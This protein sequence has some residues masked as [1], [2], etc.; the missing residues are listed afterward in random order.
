MSVTVRYGQMERM[1]KDCAQGYDIRRTTHGYRVKWNKQCYPDIPKFD[2]IEIG[3]IR[4]M[5]RTLGIN[6][7][8]AQKHGCY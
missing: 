7:N 1:L 6:K 5:V 3:H 2:N 8:C 4:K